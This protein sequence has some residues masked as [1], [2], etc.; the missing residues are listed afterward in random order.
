LLNKVS[1]SAQD[2]DR[3]RPEVRAHLGHLGQQ[4]VT[5]QFLMPR[6]ARDEL[7]LIKNLL[8]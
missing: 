1:L 6:L 4:V 5:D 7:A 2:I 3:Y 8:V